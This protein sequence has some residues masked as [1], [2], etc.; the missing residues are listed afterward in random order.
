MQEHWVGLTCLQFLHRMNG[1]KDCGRVRKAFRAQT[2]AALLITGRHILSQV[3]CTSSSLAR[4]C[5][6]LLQ[7][8]RLRASEG[9]GTRAMTSISRS[10]GRE[11][12]KERSSRSA[13]VMCVC[14]C[15]CARVCVCV[16]VC[17]C[18]CCVCVCVCVCNNYNEMNAGS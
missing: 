14:V 9:C 13:C 18:V 1:T 8:K 3:A 15:V 6:C 7:R 4:P 11:V 12:S 16:F 2:D 10:L 17:V 5:K